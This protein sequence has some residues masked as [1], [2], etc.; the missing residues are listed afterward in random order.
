MTRISTI[1]MNEQDTA[2]KQINKLAAWMNR[3]DIQLYN[4]LHVFAQ[5]PTKNAIILQLCELFRRR[6]AHKINRIKNDGE[7]LLLTGWL[8]MRSHAGVDG[9][10]VWRMMPT[11]S[12]LEHRRPSDVTTIEGTCCAAATLRRDTTGTAWD[13]VM[14]HEWSTWRNTLTYDSNRAE[15]AA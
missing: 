3:Y 15:A 14:K 2:I 8:L 7:W 9:G 10:P 1:G 5:I 13:W 4:I 12:S 11:T 6:R